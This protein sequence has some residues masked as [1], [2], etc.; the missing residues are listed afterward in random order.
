MTDVAPV[1]NYCYQPFSFEGP[2]LNNTIIKKCSKESNKKVFGNNGREFVI[3]LP[4]Q[5]KCKSEQ[6]SL[7][8]LKIDCHC[9]NNYSSLLF[10]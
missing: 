8:L 9:D 10:C 7:L 2:F 1:K 5:A 6:M 4:K 3:S